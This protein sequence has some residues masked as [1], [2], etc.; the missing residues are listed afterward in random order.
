MFPTLPDKFVVPPGAGNCNATDSAK[1]LYR[2]H[3]NPKDDEI[4]AA[5]RRA[6]TEYTAAH[7]DRY[8]DVLY[9]LTTEDTA[10]VRAFAATMRHEG[11]GTVL[12]TPDLTLDAEQTE[13]GMAVDM[14]IARRAE[15]FI[16]NGVRAFFGCGRRGRVLTIRSGR[17]SQATSF[18]VGWS[19]TS[20]RS[21]TASGDV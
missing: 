18:M 11:W 20:R 7:P 21:R 10:W 17:R 1:E 6:R 13:V 16:G 9:V 14:E 12:G 15:V 2:R 3:C 5:I 8:L 4:V 19:I